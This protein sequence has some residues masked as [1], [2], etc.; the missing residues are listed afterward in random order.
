M[1]DELVC[2]VDEKDNVIATATRKEMRQKNLLHRCTYVLVFNSKGEIFITKRTK[3]KD[4]APGLYEIGQGGVV[5][6]GET[7]EQ[8]ARRELFEE[9]GIKTELTYLFDF[10]FGDEKSKFLAKVFMCKYDGKPTLQETEIEQGS[11]FSLEKLKRTL[12]ANPELFTKDS[13]EMI[14][15]YFEHA[16]K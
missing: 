14:R 16:S 10:R 2:I 5:G 9:L 7:Y 11:F 15:K 1:K 6:T 3:T 12:Q 8:N 13:I 4:V